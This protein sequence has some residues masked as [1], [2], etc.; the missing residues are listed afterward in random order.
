MGPRDQSFGVILAS[1][2]A[3]RCVGALLSGILDCDETFNFWEPTHF[4]LYGRGLQTWEWS[5][6]YALRSYLYVLDHAAFGALARLAGAGR[7]AVFYFIRVALAIKSAGCEALLVHAARASY[8]RPIGGWTW[9]FLA[10]SPGMFHAAVAYL[11]SSFAM[12]FMALCWACWAPSRASPR[13]A[14][15]AVGAAAIVGWPFAALLG[16]PLALQ[17]V[18]APE[19][20]PARFA[21]Y[22][23]QC[24]AVLVPLVGLADLA[25]YGR[26]TLSPLNVLRY[27]LW[28]KGSGSEL[29]GVEPFW[30]YARNLALN[31]N[32]ALP[33]AAV[34]VAVLVLAP[35]RVATMSAPALR[36]LR[37]GACAA[38]LWVCVLSC[39]PHKEERFM[40]PAYPPLCLAAAVGAEALVRGGAAVLAPRGT[41]AHT[42]RARL[43]LALTLALGCASALLSASR[44]T[45]LVSYYSAPLRL[46]G[47]ISRPGGLPAVG[48]GV[49]VARVPDAPATRCDGALRLCVGGEWHRFPSSF[50]LPDD[51]CVSFVRSPF[52]GILPQPFGAGAGATRTVPTHMNNANLDEP[53]RYVPLAACHYLVELEAE[54]DPSRLSLRREWEVALRYPYL[55]ASRSPAL[56]RALW[57]PWLSAR[58]NVYASYVLL[59]RV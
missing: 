40:F 53:G 19:H 9:F 10:T 37:A 52:R 8:G 3:V 44:A 51:A 46:Y 36:A 18:C 55:D 39:L 57:L 4:L 33:L 28:P 11:P 7:P 27:N 15:A 38:W 29:Y 6:A 58:D 14:V 16:V 49:R 47:Q 54:H 22:A 30:F 13:L 56:T 17:L 45:A 35:T 26:L 21:T 25:F 42:R 43:A 32:A 41:H 23:A 12:Y 34:G 48:A 2:L 59:R 50:L 24:A 5:P 20:G 31:L 1:L